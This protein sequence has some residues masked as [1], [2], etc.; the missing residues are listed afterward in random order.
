LI[1]T[2]VIKVDPEDPEIAKI[3][4]AASVLKKGGLV[5]FP[6]ETVYGL[7]ANLAN[8]KSMDRLIKVKQ[9]PEEKLFSI[10]IAEKDKIEE[11]ARDIPVGVYKLIDKFWPGPLTI[12]L[13]SKKNNQQT[14]GIRMPS[15]KVALELINLAKVPIVA[16]SA[17]IS[18]KKPP[19][20]AE[21][22][23]DYFDGKIDMLI[24][25]GKTAL[26][27]SSSVADFTRTNFEVVR[28]AAIKKS[29][30][31]KVINTKNILIICTGN[32]CRSVM[33]EE[34]LKKK[35]DKRQDVQIY[36][37]GTGAAAG[38]A[39][40]FETQKLLEE[41]G[42]DVSKHKAEQ[43]TDV[44]VKKADLILVMQKHHEDSV[45]RKYPFAKNR[46][47]LLKEFAKIDDGDLNIP[48]PMGMSEGFYK[49]VFLIIK[50]AI[51]R[52]SQLI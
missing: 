31:E 16:P 14:V 24:D 39:V 7:A 26:G 51:E 49:K 29:D 5:A 34:L 41:E 50:Q 45:L 48:D 17:N 32:S 20:T 33:A 40:T 38:M 15:N 46:L 44:M 47:Y 2:E 1:K 30:I 36:S 11:F 8:K 27:V 13:H 9:R 25:G 28:E 6:T 3:K 4:K 18:G 23:L 22:V 37:A 42:I 10:H 21:E 12:I 43:L 35:L 19:T 52:I